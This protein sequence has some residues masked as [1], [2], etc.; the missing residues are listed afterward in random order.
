VVGEVVVEVVDL[1][2]LLLLLLLP[3]RSSLVSTST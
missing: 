3:S 2:L 1:L